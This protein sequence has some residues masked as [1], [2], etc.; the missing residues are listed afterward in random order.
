MGFGEKR[1]YMLLTWTKTLCQVRKASSHR[2]SYLIGISKETVNERV[3]DKGPGKWKVPDGV[4]HHKMTKCCEIAGQEGCTSLPTALFQW[5]V[6]P[7]H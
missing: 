6:L 5:Y 4:Q 3:R 7:T 1:C 2:H